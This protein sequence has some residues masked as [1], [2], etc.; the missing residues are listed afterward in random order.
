[1]LLSGQHQ[2]CVLAGRIKQ[3]IEELVD[4]RTQRAPALAHFVRVHLVLKGIDPDA[5]TD[6][7]PDEPDKVAMLE[8]MIREFGGRKRG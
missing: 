5:Y 8:G 7:S 3:L 4:L 6:K 1:M 2:G